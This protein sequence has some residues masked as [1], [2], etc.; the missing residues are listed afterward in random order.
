MSDHPIQDAIDNIPKNQLEIR[1]EAEKL[2][3][4]KVDADVS[5]TLEREKELADGSR[6]IGVTA[7]VSTTRGGY[8]GAFFRRIWR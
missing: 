1:G 2:P 7:G 8:V 3:G 4:Q 6:A 5:V